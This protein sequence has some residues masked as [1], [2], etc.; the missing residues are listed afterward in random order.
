MKSYHQEGI[1]TFYPGWRVTYQGASG[2]EK[3]HHEIPQGAK[4]VLDFIKR[5]E[6]KGG[7]IKSIVFYANQSVGSTKPFY[8]KAVTK[9]ELERINDIWFD[10]MIHEIT[11]IDNSQ[12]F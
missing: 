2:E 12:N 11:A 9:D 5:I 1:M 4:L 10:Q 8:E 3:I 7:T 6:T